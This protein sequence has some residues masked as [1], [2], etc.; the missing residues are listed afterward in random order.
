MDL[1]AISKDKAIIIENKI[2][3]GLN[4]IDKNEETTQLGKYIKDIKT[5][6]NIDENEIYGLIFVPD[7]NQFVVDKMRQIQRNRRFED[8]WKIYIKYI[9]K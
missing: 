3:S 2:Q 8:F 5:D 1:F 7:Y 4:G 6:N 9:V